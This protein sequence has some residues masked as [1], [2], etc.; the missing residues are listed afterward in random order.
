MREGGAVGWKG[1][2]GGVVSGLMGNIWDKWDGKI[3]NSLG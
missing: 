1:G 3:G 2:D